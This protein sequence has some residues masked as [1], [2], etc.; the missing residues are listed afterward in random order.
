MEKKWNEKKGKKSY[1][2]QIIAFTNNGAME[3]IST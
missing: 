2:S 3:G 1:F